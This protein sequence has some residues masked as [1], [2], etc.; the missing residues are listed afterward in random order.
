VDLITGD[1][2]EGIPGFRI[3]LPFVPVPITQVASNGV[4]VAMARNWRQ[5]VLFDGTTVRTL[6]LA[7]AAFRFA[8]DDQARVLYFETGTGAGAEIAVYD[9]ASDLEQALVSCPEGAWQP[10]LSRD[11]RRLLFLSR[12]N[13]AG[14]NDQGR[15]QAFLIRT[16]GS[17][18]R[19]LTR[20]EDDVTSAVLAGDGMVAYASTGKDQLLRIDVADGRVE[21][22]IPVTPALTD[23]LV[24][25]APGSE[26]ELS[27]SNLT[28]SDLLAD[29]SPHPGVLGG[30]SILLN[31]EP[32][33]VAWVTPNRIAVQVPWETA[34]DKA[35]LALE[36]PAKSVLERGTVLDVR[37]NWLKF[38]RGTGCEGPIT[39]GY[40]YLVYALH[41]D[42]RATVT[43]CSPAWNGEVIHVYMTGLG[44]AE[45]AVPTGVTAPAEPPSIPV[46]FPRTCELSSSS[47]SGDVGVVSAVL[48]PD[49]VGVYR[50][51][52]RLPDTLGVSNSWSL[53]CGTQPSEA[54]G[55]L[56]IRPKP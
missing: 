54:S 19:Q 4:V 47:F 14:R 10:S 18:L 22:V 11:G 25:S 56:L 7:R 45:P 39:D 46:E 9:V 53:R 24:Y 43:D 28:T 37:R 36:T 5:L 52:I 6:K 26:V 29:R 21:E 40:R 15:L 2:V 30:V 17:E 50:V 1:R 27:G 48:A 42:Y 8:M 41:E 16:D 49:T 32:V 44:P 33:P 34:L 3:N 35:E 20:P 31:G 51:D 38:L 23:E 13:F 55:Y 12:A